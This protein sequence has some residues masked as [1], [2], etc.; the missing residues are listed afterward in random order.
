MLE[1]G[2]FLSPA[3]TFLSCLRHAGF[4]CAKLCFRDTP[5]PSPLPRTHSGS[6]HKLFPFPGGSYLTSLP[7]QLLPI[8]QN[9]AQVSFPPGSQGWQRCL[10]FTFPQHQCLPKTSVCLHCGNY[11]S[12]LCPPFIWGFPGF[13]IHR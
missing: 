11:W 6:F 9:P 10:S 5:S 1:L 4:Q 13:L 2:L 3:S 8:L 12:C 7:H